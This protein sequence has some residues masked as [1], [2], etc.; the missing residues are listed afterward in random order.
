M[1]IT[2]CEGTESLTDLILCNGKALVAHMLTALCV[3]IIIA[4]VIGLIVFAESLYLKW[5]KR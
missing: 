2:R 5:K 1:I 4:A 3:L